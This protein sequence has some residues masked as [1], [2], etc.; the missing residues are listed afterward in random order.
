MPDALNRRP[1][2]MTVAE[3]YDWPGDGT[4]RTFELVDGELR[5][6]SPG[7]PTHGKIQ[8]RL[9]AL[10][11]NQL[12]AASSLCQVV[13]APGIITARHAHINMRVPDLGVTC[14]PDAPGDRALPDP[15]VLIEILSPSNA[16][17]TWDNVWAYTTISSVREIVVVHSTAVLAEVLRRGADSGWP[18]ETDKIE[19]DGTLSLQ[20]I[21]FACP[22]RDVYKQTHLG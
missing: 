16:A 7:S 12:A 4:G 17:D 5:P 11:L 2:L 6:M 8:M 3:F 21:G 15:V 19:A 10:I 13:C 18:T 22:L 14:T 1:H 9:G 20:S